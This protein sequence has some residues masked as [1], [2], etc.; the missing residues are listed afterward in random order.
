MIPML[1]SFDV[2][3]LNGSENFI[4]I[5]S[6]SENSVSF[7]IEDFKD[8]CWTGLVISNYRKAQMDIYLRNV[9]VTTAPKAEVIRLFLYGPFKD[10]NES[11]VWDNFDVLLMRSNM[12]KYNNPFPDVSSRDYVKLHKSDKAVL[13][14]YIEEISIKEMEVSILLGIK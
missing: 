9:K 1:N 7:I 3:T 14:I 13:W 2:Y 8:W 4:R 11:S 6:I 12:I 10:P 5:K